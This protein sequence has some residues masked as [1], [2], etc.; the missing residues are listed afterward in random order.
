MTNKWSKY[1][2]EDRAMFYRAL[3]TRKEG[4]HQKRSIHSPIKKQKRL[5]PENTTEH[6]VH[7]GCTR[8]TRRGDK[9]TRREPAAATVMT[10]RREDPTTVNKLERTYGEPSI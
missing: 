3:Q 2:L 9:H 4:V 8:D 5:T 7:L 10:R 1:R 6:S